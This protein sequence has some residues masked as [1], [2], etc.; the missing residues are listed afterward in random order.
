LRL[1]KQIFDAICECFNQC[2]GH[3]VGRSK[4]GQGTRGGLAKD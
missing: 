2:H 3:K 4:A 1:G